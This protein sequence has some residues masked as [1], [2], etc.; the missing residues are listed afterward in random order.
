MITPL[1]LPLVAPLELPLEAPLELPLPPP[2]ELPEVGAVPVPTHA[3][4]TATPPCP[5]HSVT[6]PGCEVQHAAP[7]TPP[8]VIP[9][10]GC[11]HHPG[12]HAYPHPQA[13]GGGVTGGPELGV[14]VQSL[15]FASEQHER[16]SGYVVDPA[17]HA[18]NGS[19]SQ[20]PQEA[21]EL[22][23]AEQQMLG[24]AQP[25]GHE[26]GV[27]ET[28]VTPPVTGWRVSPVFP[29]DTT[30]P[31]HAIPTGST[32]RTKSV[33]NGRK[34]FDRAIVRSP[35]ASMRAGGL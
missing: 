15:G 22:G 20:A 31:L 1:E 4:G 16:G 9:P 17:A 18:R 28:V 11:A 34:T 23:P 14:S 33:A 8:G 3:V 35:C 6:P 25:A 12:G 32:A 13:G 10:A 19:S 21:A 24:C 2:L 26:L 5:T 29:R 30:R 7:S 27:C